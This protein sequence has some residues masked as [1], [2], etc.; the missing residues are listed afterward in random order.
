MVSSSHLELHKSA[1]PGLGMVFMK[2]SLLDHQC[3]TNVKEKAMDRE[4]EDRMEVDEEE[5][6][7]EQV[8]GVERD[9]EHGN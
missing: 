7:L 2:N 5:Q 9:A 8:R 1:A 6:R 3:P 4:L